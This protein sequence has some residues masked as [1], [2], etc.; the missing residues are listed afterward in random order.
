MSA[1]R[2]ARRDGSSYT[3]IP[4]KYLLVIRGQ[5][6]QAAVRLFTE[7]ERNG[8]TADQRECPPIARRGATDRRTRLSHQSMCWSSAGIRANQR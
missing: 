5:S 2:P 7:P 3:T 4:S 6:R 1:D 8:F